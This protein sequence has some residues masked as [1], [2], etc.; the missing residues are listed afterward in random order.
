MT[1]VAVPPR[2]DRDAVDPRA[3]VQAL[4]D[5]IWLL[6]DFV[7]GSSANGL[8]QVAVA[9]P[10]NAGHTLTTAA[11]LRA[12]SD[13]EVR[14][15]QGNQPGLIDRAE[16]QIVRDALNTAIQPA[17]GLTVAY[18][19]MVTGPLRRRQA[20]RFNLAQRAY[21]GLTSM[22]R[23]HRCVA[24]VILWLAVLA[25]GF[26]VWESAK[27]SL[28]KALLQNMDALHVQQLALGTEKVK[29]ELA[30]PPASEPAK[31]LYDVATPLKPPLGTYRLCDRPLVVQAFLLKKT[32]P[33]YLASVA[34]PADP[35]V[36]A[37]ES[38]E[39]RDVCGR[40]DVVKANIALVHVELADYQENWAGMAGG[41]F[42]A[43]GHILATIRTLVLAPASATTS[44][45][46]KADDIELRIA[47]LLL[48]WGNFVLPITFGFIGSAVFV[49]LDHANKLRASQLHPRDRSLA[50]IRLALGLVVGACVGL[51]VSASAP[52]GLPAPAGVTPL[53]GALTLS[54]SGIAFLAGFA[55][56][57]V[58]TMLQGLVSRV[59]TV[60]AGK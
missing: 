40:D 33:E 41:V 58:F 44:R 21:G 36:L 55:V 56:E 20:S 35:G 11:L 29:L 30:Q 57:T 2:P 16:M 31:G 27:V 12:V 42:A 47:P 3:V 13:V 38:A 9:D 54:A 23:W 15:A 28:G 26:A 14:L 48:V 50:G 51:F 34:P 43:P 37:H 22:A 52:T 1:G 45:V 18:S 59:F 4:V 53:A 60:P 8:A 17:S 49:T 46:V 5:E 24:S 6:V 32:L 10:R 25:T 39:A 19:T 7:A